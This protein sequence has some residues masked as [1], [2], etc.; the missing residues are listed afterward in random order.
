MPGLSPSSFS[1]SLCVKAIFR[2]SVEKDGKKQIRGREETRRGWKG[3][4]KELKE[5]GAQKIGC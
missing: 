5:K 4:T 1:L 3:K 2:R